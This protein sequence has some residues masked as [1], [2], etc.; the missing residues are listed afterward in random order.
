MMWFL[1][2]YLYQKS[3]RTYILHAEL[4]YV[5]DIIR[6]KLY[7]T[8]IKYEFRHNIDYLIKFGEKLSVE[9]RP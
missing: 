3:Q 8:C 7:I 1:L 2:L 5:V 6:G 9:N 4:S